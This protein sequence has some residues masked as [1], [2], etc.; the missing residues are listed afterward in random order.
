MEGISLKRP[1]VLAL[2]MIL[3]VV[4]LAV[5]AG[6]AWRYRHVGVNLGPTAPASDEREIEY[7][8]CS[9]HPYLREPEP[10]NCPAC[11]MKLEAVYKRTTSADGESQTMP[12][13]VHVSVEEERLLGI[14]TVVARRG[15]FDRAIRT[16]GRVE[17]S[18]ERLE[19]VHTRFEGWVDRLFVNS[20]GQAV[21]R[22]EPLF[23]IYSPQ[24]VATQEEYLLALKARE[25]LGANRDADAAAG[26]K[27]LLSAA[28]DRLRLLEVSDEA[29]R[30]LETTRQIER[31]V[32]IYSP[33]SGYVQTRN[34]TAGQQIMPGT[35]LYVIADLTNVWVTADVFERDMGGVQVGQRVSATFAGEQDVVHEG[36]ISFIYPYLDENTRTNKIRI[37]L[38]NPGQKLKP[39]M[40]G[41]ITIASATRDSFILVPNDAVMI[42]GVRN[43][44]FV[45]TGP[46]TYAPVEVR[47]GDSSHD[48]YQILSGLKE[49][50]VVVERGNFFLD[51]ESQ[52]R[53]TGAGTTAH[54]GHDVGQE[55]A[56][57]SR[58]EQNPPHTGH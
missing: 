43:V 27:S 3:L 53:M 51:S 26:V 20:V 28:R 25:A 15:G 35:D 49:G 29:V 6:M 58:A 5:A 37:S 11:G 55:N 8:T 2:V 44:V 47:I 21:N 56:P 38:D 18:E 7:Y 45:R 36:R 52:L 9:M 50:D 32:T 22:G 23:S 10:G 19:H 46:G 13:T 41:E 42:T 34:I 24:L 33:V 16:V 48:S 14:R 31:T 17:V 1:A 12:G 30:R 54:A 4:V 40:F 57:A 39:G